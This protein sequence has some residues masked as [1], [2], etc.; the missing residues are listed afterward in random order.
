[1]E[2][3]T[4]PSADVLNWAAN[5]VQ[6]Y[7]NR[8]VIVMTHYGIDESTSFGTQGSA[9]YNK[10]KV[11]PNFMLFTC[12]HIHQTDGESRRSDVYNGNTVH[13][14][15]SDYQGRTGGG[16]G[17]LR[18]YEFDPSLN[19]LSAKTYS[20]YTGT[21]ETDADSQF[22]LAVNLGTSSNNFTLVGEL[23]SV[24]SGTNACL[25]WPNLSQLT[26]MNGIL[27][28]VMVSLLQLVL[29]G[30]LRHRLIHH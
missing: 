17:L 6:T 15:L 30:H 10:L 3:N 4:S 13:T 2:Y 22:E 20:P 26:A 24:P 18:I 7:S 28:L 23:N 11:Y 25:N 19:K 27:S 12:G 5:L 29:Y 9:I 21:Y 14:I 16:N 1:M 8:K